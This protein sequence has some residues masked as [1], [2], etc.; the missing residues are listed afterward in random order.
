MEIPVTSLPW[1]HTG[2]LDLFGGSMGVLLTKFC[3]EPR[4]QYIW[5]VPDI[6][7]HTQTIIS[8]LY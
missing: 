2:A 7:A 4:V 3:E 1:Q 6:L 5:S 8:V